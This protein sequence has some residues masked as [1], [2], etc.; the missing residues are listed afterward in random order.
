MQAHVGQAVLETGNLEVVRDIAGSRGRRTPRPASL[1]G[2]YLTGSAPLCLSPP[3]CPAAA[4]QRGREWRPPARGPRPRPTRVDPCRG[5][6]HQVDEIHVERVHV[7]G[8]D[9]VI[10]VH[11]GVQ[12]PEPAG[13]ILI[14]PKVECRKTFFVSPWLSS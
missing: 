2:P 1:S 4:R 12:N 9:G 8:M 5:T 3:R 14:L 10:E 7:C 11:H 13:G 6:D